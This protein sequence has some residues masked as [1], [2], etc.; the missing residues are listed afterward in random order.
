MKLTNDIDTKIIKDYRIIDSAW[1]EFSDY[2]GEHNIKT[3]LTIECF[4][5]IF[6]IL[7]KNGKYTRMKDFILESFR[8][9][10]YLWPLVEKDQ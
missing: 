5:D 8:Y 9:D 7:N 4:E 2:I 6:K 3:P 10:C 1:D